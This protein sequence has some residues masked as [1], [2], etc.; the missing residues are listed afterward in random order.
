LEQNVIEWI[1]APEES[2]INVSKRNPHDVQSF[3]MLQQP[4]KERCGAALYDPG[5]QT[6]KQ[7]ANADAN[8]KCKLSDPLSHAVRAQDRLGDRTCKQNRCQ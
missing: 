1:Y 3:C 8:A 2:N 5:K 4:C 7:N 6:R